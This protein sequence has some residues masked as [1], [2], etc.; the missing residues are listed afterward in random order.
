MKLEEGYF[1]SFDGTK[2]FFRT[3]TQPSQDNLLLIHGYGDHSGRYSELIKQL[4]KLP[5][6]FFAFDLRGQGKSKGRR[7]DANSFNDYVHDGSA[8]LEFLTK[9]GK[10]KGGK[11]FLL[12]HSLGGLI[13][14]DLYKQ[15]PNQWKAILLSSPCF[16]LYGVAWSPLARFL[17]DKLSR[18][19][20]HLVMSNLVKPRFLFHD[21]KKMEEY[22]KDPLIEKRITCRLAHFIV[23]AC[24]KAQKEKL[25]ANIPLCVLAAGD[26]RIVS[27]EATKNWF[28]HAQAVSKWI[29]IYPNLYHEIF[30]EIHTEEPAQD[31]LQFL[32]THIAR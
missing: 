29:K 30:N 26:E 15:T 2:I 4:S 16:E 13:A 14:V 5:I 27:L 23:E 21:Q 11:F 3:W 7:V 22:L 31:L 25:E 6:S 1:P 24:L 20:P 12:G 17:T 32:S 10:I 18:L 19:T 8:Y 28:H 9:E